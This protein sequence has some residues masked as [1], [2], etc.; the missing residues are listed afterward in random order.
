MRLNFLAKIPLPRFEAADRQALHW[1]WRDYIRHQRSFLIAGLVATLIFSGVQ[2]GSLFI[3]EDIVALLINSGSAEQSESGSKQAM[4]IGLALLIGGMQVARGLSNYVITASL[5]RAAAEVVTALKREIVPR[6]I[7]LDQAYHDR[8]SVGTLIMRAN[9]LPGQLGGVFTNA[10]IGA[11]RDF[12]TLTAYIFVA[13]KL[14]WQ[15]AL[16]LFVLTPMVAILFR[17]TS[18]KSRLL[19]AEGIR[20]GKQYSSLLQEVFSAIRT[21]KIDQQ[22]TRVTTRLNSDLN[23]IRRHALSAL[24]VR[25]Y[26][27]PAVA[28]MGGISLAFII[29]VGGSQVVGGTVAPETLITFLGAVGSMQIPLRRL[30][31]VNT[32]VQSALVTAQDVYEIAHEEAQVVS[33]P[34]AK[35]DFDPSGD[36]VLQGVKF[37]YHDDSPWLFRSLDIEIKGG[38][39]TAIVGPTGSG[40][41]S[42]LA[43]LARLYDPQEGSVTLDGYDIRQLDLD[44][45]RAG[46]AIVS[47]DIVL[48][49][50]TLR[51]NI[52]FANL[53]ASEAELDRIIEAVQ[54]KELDEQLGE[55]T[56]GNRGMRLSGGQRQRVAIARALIQSAPVLLLDEA[57]SALDQRTEAQ[58]A[59]QL[60]SI[61]Q[62]RTLV[63]I[64]HRLSLVKNADCIYML[65]QGMLI[66]AGSHAELM[67]K[68]GMYAS[69]YL[70]QQ[71]Q[72]A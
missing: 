17:V 51:A 11:G 27:S 30:M 50:E 41:T 63:T 29:Y 21:I 36:L 31:T 10:A 69:M 53:E 65:E 60:D 37:R 7:R 39:H 48:F 54:L 1:L 58:I 28:V 32:T 64:A 16:T 33:L 56:L 57:T 5:G 26:I 52:H 59:A 9:G 70:A 18:R 66:E 72:Y 55:E 3:F 19:Q 45:L 40:K 42:I 49:D 13:F 71:R 34:S 25:A 22:E 68:Q 2:A 46:M 47:Q 23:A 38:Q 35:Q 6:V 62:G 67:D 61:G 43:L 4:L 44:Y 8:E 24:K 12:L 20:L 14:Q 15:W